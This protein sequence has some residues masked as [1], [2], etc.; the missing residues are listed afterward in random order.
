MKILNPYI[1]LFA[2]AANETGQKKAI[3]EIASSNYRQSHF[4]F[5]LIGSDKAVKAM[6][7]MVQHSRELESGDTS[8]DQEILIRD[9]GNILV[10]I[11]KDLGNRRSRLKEKDMLIAYIKDINKIM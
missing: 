5:N 11:R 2:N 1:S 10:A 8:L 3:K 6:N 4:E 7:Q 9:W